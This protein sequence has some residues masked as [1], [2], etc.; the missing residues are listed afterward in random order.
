VI[1]PA[2][3]DIEGLIRR[4]D[5]EFGIQIGEGQGSIKKTTFRIGHVGHLTDEELDY[6]TT[7]FETCI[8]EQ[9]RP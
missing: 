5:A 9:R 8:R 1:P 7:C 2:G 3:F 6:F 4:L